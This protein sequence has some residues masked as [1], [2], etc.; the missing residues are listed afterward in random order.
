MFIISYKEGENMID[1]V[2]SESAMGSMK[3]AKHYDSEVWIASASAYIGKRPSDDEIE[4]MYAGQALAGHSQDVI[5]ISFALDI[6]SL[7]GGLK[8]D[9]RKA[10]LRDIVARPIGMLEHPENEFKEYWSKSM[11]QL[12]LLKEKAIQGETIRIWYSDTPSD[13][14]AYY[15]ICSLLKDHACS[16]RTIKLPQYIERED[17]AIVAFKSWGE[18]HPGQFYRFLQYE[19]SLSPTIVKYNAIIWQSLVENSS[20]LRVSLNGELKNVSE[21]FYDEFIIRHLPDE[22]TKMGRVIGNVLGIEALKISDYWIRNRIRSMI[23]AGQIKVVKGD[24]MEYGF[25][26]QKTFN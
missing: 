1:V 3:M 26:I 4:A 22:P 16:I 2:F 5:C 7:K 17:H 10:I 24:E 8:S 20:Q 18:V 19:Q 6:G 25:I 23:T 14:C 11:A 12:D 13:L 15:Y 21:T 9:T